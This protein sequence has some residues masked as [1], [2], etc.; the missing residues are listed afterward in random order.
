MGS[1]SNIHLI[2]EPNEL[3]NGE[4][5]LEIGNISPIVMG[6][7]DINNL[8]TFFT[9][10]VGMYFLNKQGIDRGGFIHLLDH[11]ND[12]ENKGSTWR[13]LCVDDRK[14]QTNTTN[15]AFRFG[16]PIFRINNFT[17]NKLTGIRNIPDNRNSTVAKTYINDF[18]KDKPSMISAYASAIRVMGNGAI[19]K[20]Y[21]KDYT[22]S[23]QK[24]KSIEQTWRYPANGSL[25]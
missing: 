24:E 4:T 6:R 25:H 23:W 7:M 1:L 13:R 16:S 9:N 12:S 21:Y 22:N 19:S 17:D 8:D 3:D 20:T 18:Y 2:G 5:I 10:S 11:I 15:Y 14:Q